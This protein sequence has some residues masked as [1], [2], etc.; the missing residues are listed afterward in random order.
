M[1]GSV[2][3]GIPL[4]PEPES[5]STPMISAVRQRSIAPSPRVRGHRFAL[6]A[7]GRLE[8]AGAGLLRRL[9][10]PTVRGVDRLLRRVYRI[11]EFSRHAQC[12]CRIAVVE[13]DCETRLPNG[14]RILR[15][16]TIGE[17]HFWSERLP[18]IPQADVD[19]RRAVKA[20][21][22]SFMSVILT[23]VLLFYFLYSGSRLAQGSLALVPP[24][25]RSQTRWLAERINPVL[26]RYI[27]GMFIVVA[28]SPSRRS[29]HGLQSPG[30]SACRTR[31]CWSLRRDSSS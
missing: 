1:R 22:C 7:D 2:P 17:L 26:G 5:F 4:C 11:H 31:S 6:R 18:A 19:L 12:I 24:R 10:E 27:R 14:V 28:S 30:C 23:F 25:Y 9:C 29:F 16:E 3:E 13:N 20:V 15:G 21:F 8:P